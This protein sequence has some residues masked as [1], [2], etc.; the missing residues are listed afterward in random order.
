MCL[1][2]LQFFSEHMLSNGIAGPFGG[3]IFSFFRELP[4]TVPHSACINL[5]SHQQ[6]KRVF[7]SPYPLQY[8][9]FVDFLIMAFLIWN[10]P[11]R[12]RRNDMD[13]TET[14]WTLTEAEDIKKRQEY[15]EE[16]YF[17]KALMTQIPMMVWL[18][19]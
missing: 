2:E 15:T 5:Y 7:C 18:L 16:L 1:F 4:Y 10:G 14:I 6:Y 11:D 12:G 13:Q 9:L 3:S 19:T 8:L 17:K